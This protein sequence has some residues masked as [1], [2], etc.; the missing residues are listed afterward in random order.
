MGGEKQKA[1][2]TGN[3]LFKH[4]PSY[5][6]KSRRENGKTQYVVK[7]ENQPGEQKTT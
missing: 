7:I 1:R 2:I 5:I 4:I 6:D 3:C